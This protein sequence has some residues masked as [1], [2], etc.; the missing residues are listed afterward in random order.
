MKQ[1]LRTTAITLVALGASAANAQ[2]YKDVFKP[3]GASISVGGTGLFSTP[4]DS[5]PTSGTFNVPRVGGGTLSETVSNQHQDTTWSAGFITSLQFHPKPWAGLELNYGFS[6]F[7]EVYSYNYSSTPTVQS[8]KVTTDM[9]E[10]TAAYQFHPK[11]I[12]FQ[13]FVNV[14]GGY[15]E[16]VP[17]TAS[18]QFRETGLLEAGFDIPT[19]TKHIG[20]RIEGRS[21]YYR[22]PNFENSAISTRSW[23][24]TT[25]P[26]ISTYYRF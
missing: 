19:H 3:Y 6:R 22:A 24:V 23:R 26:S 1:L 17:G 25:E 18:G 9:H 2:F 4:L 15:V 10:Y 16:F 5:N 8:S 21:L 7:S 13:P 20:F 11:H 12:P 14:G